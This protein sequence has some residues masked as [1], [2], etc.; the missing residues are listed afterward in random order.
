VK[1]RDLHDKSVVVVGASSGVGRATALAFADH[2][3]RLVLVA[4][5]TSAL[6][7]LA[8]ECRAR[9]ATAVIAPADV[10]DERATDAVV[11]VALD[12]YGAIDV[13]IHLAAGIIAGRFGDESDDEVRRLVDVDVLG[14]VRGARSAL[15]VFRRQGH[16]TLV[17]VSSVLGAVPNPVVPLY[18]MCKFAVVGF[19]RALAAQTADDHDIHIGLVLP[20]PVDTPLFEHAA[21]HTGTALRAVP[22]A[23][24]PER[25]AAAIVTC[26]RKRRREVAVGATARIVL[27]GRRVLPAVT[28]RV[29]A[30]YSGRMLVQ[31]AVP[32]PPTS[33]T[34]FAAPRDGHVVGSW[35]TVTV[36]RVLGD[37]LG[38]ALAR[39][40]AGQRRSRLA[41][42]T[43]EGPE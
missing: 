19:T 32:V 27:L 11:Q 13:W 16:G 28:D 31:R 39:R 7:G 20:G 10:A 5:S 29:V 18:V 12:R 35:R 9:G 8:T 37:R 24:S 26:V 1:A 3:C 14:Y 23:C 33:G 21:N 43:A 22:P 6:E 2:G 15:T 40:G 17:N 36:R 4:R 30:G 38:Y 25:A 42:G 34:L 41:A